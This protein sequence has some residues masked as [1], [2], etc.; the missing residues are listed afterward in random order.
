MNN[1]LQGL[2][3]SRCKRLYQHFKYKPWSQIHVETSPKICVHIFHNRTAI[4]S[5]DFSISEQ[6]GLRNAVQPV[7]L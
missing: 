1:E 2:L 4:N 6:V 3:H 5:H 7:E